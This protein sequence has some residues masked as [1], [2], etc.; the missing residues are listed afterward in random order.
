MNLPASYNL[1]WRLARPAL[2][3]L[4]NRRAAAGKEDRKRLGERY[5]RVEGRAALPLSPIFWTC[6]KGSDEVPR[7]LLLQMMRMPSWWRLQAT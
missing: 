3:L 2:P 1:M 4:L 6:W 5:G 7:V